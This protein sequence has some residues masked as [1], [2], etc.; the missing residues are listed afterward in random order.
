MVRV[1]GS[2]WWGQVLRLRPC[3]VVRSREVPV[4]DGFGWFYSGLR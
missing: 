2:G 4:P 1:V 3:G